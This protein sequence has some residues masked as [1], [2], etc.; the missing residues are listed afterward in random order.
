[1]GGNKDEN[2]YRGETNQQSR[3]VKEQKARS[4][5]NEKGGGHTQ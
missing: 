1:M 5:R 2:K 4:R 3:K